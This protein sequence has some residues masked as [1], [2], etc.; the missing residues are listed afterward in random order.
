MNSYNNREK[1]PR[2]TNLIPKLDK[3][4]TLRTN[5]YYYLGTG[6]CY[7]GFERKPITEA[8]KETMTFLVTHS[9]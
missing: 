1:V 9:I 2:K 8:T 4:F 5:V 3:L 6:Y 7:W